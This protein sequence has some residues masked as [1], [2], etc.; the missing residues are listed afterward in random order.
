MTAN[1]FYSKIVTDE[2]LRETIM[3]GSDDYP[4]CYYYEDIYAFDLHCID[5]HWHPEAEFVFIEKGTA[6]FLI[7]SDRYVLTEGTGLFINVQ[8]LHRFEADDHAII[9]NIVFS[10]SLLAAK[11]SLIDQKYIQPLLRC[12][13]PCQIFTAAVP[14]QN[15]ILQILRAVFALQENSLPDELQTVQLLLQL[16]QHLYKHTPLSENAFLSKPQARIQAQ[17]Q[18]MMQY[19]HQN[20]A[21]TITLEELAQTVLLSKSSVLNIFQKQL[22]TSPIHYLVNYR[23]TRASKLLTE[24]ENSVAQIAHDTGFENNGYF[25]RKFKDLFQLTPS[26]YRKSKR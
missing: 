9:P 14:W 5:W 15:E 26:E 17:L 18:L 10:P 22:H 4:F 23:L 20:Y 2:T 19:I 7:G 11:D 21:R 16:W 24:T 1:H 8:I 13:A 6:T 25:C 12:S 3:H